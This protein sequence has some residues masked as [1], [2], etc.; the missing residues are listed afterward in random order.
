MKKLIFLT[1]L[2]TTLFIGFTACSDNMMED[3]MEESGVGTPDFSYIY[4]LSAKLGYDDTNDR[5][6]LLLDED[7]KQ[8]IIDTLWMYG[9]LYVPKESY[10]NYNSSTLYIDYKTSDQDIY[11]KL[12]ELVGL[13]ISTV[14]SGRSLR[15]GDDVYENGWLVSLDDITVKTTSR[16]GQFYP[17]EPKVFPEAYITVPVSRSPYIPDNQYEV[18]NVFVHVL[19]KTNGTGLNKEAVTANVLDALGD[20]HEANSTNIKFRSIGNEYIDYLTEDMIKNMDLRLESEQNKIFV[21]K[22]PFRRIRCLCP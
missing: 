18:V 10:N 14:I 16:S 9:L 21:K 12:E 3:D 7:K 1:A 19:R 2:F 15:L 17:Y 6:I 20:F 13:D 5:Y 22:Q 11:S 8:S 4:N